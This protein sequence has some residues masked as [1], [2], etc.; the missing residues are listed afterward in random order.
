MVISFQKKKIRQ[1]VAIII[2][3]NFNLKF[4]NIRFFN[5]NTEGTES[6]VFYKKIFFYRDVYFFIDRFRDITAFKSENKIKN[7]FI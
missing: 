7:V 1:Q 3:T 5:L 4:N 6:T 2:I